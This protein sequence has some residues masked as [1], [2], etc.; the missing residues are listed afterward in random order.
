MVKADPQGGEDAFIAKYPDY[1]LVTDRL[2]NNFSGLVSDKTSTKLVAGNPDV[3]RRIMAEVGDK[4]ATVLGAV[5]NDDNYAFSSGAQAWLLTHKIPGTSKKFKDYADAL[6][7][8]RSAI[9][10][11]GWADY[12]KLKDIVTKEL[13]SQ[14]YSVEQGYGLAVLKRYKDAFVAS[15]KESNSMWYDEFTNN[16]FGGKGSRQ[17]ATV[18]ALTIAANTPQLWDKLKVQ[19]RWHSVVSYLNLRYAVYDEL[20]KIGG[21]KPD[22]TLKY[23]IENSRVI[24][25]KRKVDAIVND[26]RKKDLEF[27][28]FYDRYFDGDKF[29]YVYEEEK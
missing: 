11:K 10:N 23:D 22:G 20:A 25:L 19:P 13:E 17:A 15:S 7:S 14:R 2:S 4:N 24:G 29:D 9:V 28:R 8:T 21:F 12:T 16:S 26:M 6:E 27:G 3:V 18:K 1:W 5:F